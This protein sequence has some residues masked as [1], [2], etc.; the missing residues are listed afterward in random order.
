MP[1]RSPPAASAY[2]TLADTSDEKQERAPPNSNLSTG[3]CRRTH[4]QSPY[5]LMRASQSDPAVARVRTR[6]YPRAAMLLLG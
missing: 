5:V 1:P 4:G 6:R 2:R 3:H